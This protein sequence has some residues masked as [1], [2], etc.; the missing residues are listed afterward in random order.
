MGNAGR[1]DAF[2]DRHVGFGI[3]WRESVYY[4][5]IDIAISIPFYTF[6]ISLGKE[7]E[8]GTGED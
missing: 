3:R 1:F 2:Y 5:F 6:Q 4:S 8:D 7:I